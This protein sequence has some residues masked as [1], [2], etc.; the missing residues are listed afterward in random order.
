MLSRGELDW[1]VNLGRKVHE[2]TSASFASA[3]FFF[4]DSSRVLAQSTFLAMKLGEN[5][6]YSVEVL[7]VLDFSLQVEVLGRKVHSDISLV[8]RSTWT[9]LALSAR[10]R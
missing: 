4:N 6:D 2:L 3:R 5:S 10:R 1:L 8:S 7:I 9:L